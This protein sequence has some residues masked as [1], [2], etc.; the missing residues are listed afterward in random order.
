MSI[1]TSSFNIRTST[2]GIRISGMTRKKV[3]F[4]RTISMSKKLTNICVRINRDPDKELGGL[5]RTYLDKNKESLTPHAEQ[6]LAN[7]ALLEIEGP[8]NLIPWKWLRKI[9]EYSQDEIVELVRD[10]GVKRFN[11]TSLYELETRARTPKVNEVNAFVKIFNL[12]KS[13]LI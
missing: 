6:Q 4:R 12:D 13:K 1:S 10:T 11:R 3:S 8:L 7:L 2:N 5:A 9:T